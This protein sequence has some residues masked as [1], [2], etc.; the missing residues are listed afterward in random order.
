[1][2]VVCVRVCVCVCVRVCVCVCVRARVRVLGQHFSQWA[3]LG[4]VSPSVLA[5]K[6]RASHVSRLLLHSHLLTIVFL[7]SVF[8]RFFSFFFFFLSLSISLTF[9][10]LSTCFLPWSTWPRQDLRKKLLDLEKENWRLKGV[11]DCL[12]QTDSYPV[13]LI[14]TC[15]SGVWKCSRSLP[16]TPVLDESSWTYGC[17]KFIQY[18]AG[19]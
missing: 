5:S 11:Q 19:S 9:S 10:A 15:K 4:Q 18:L 12:L 7:L 13:V 2:Q 17:R 14:S 16:Q 3:G 8:S 1:M 6:R